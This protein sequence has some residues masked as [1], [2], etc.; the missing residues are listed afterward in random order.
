LKTKVIAYIFRNKDK[1]KEIL[2]FKHRDFP[3]AGL[4]VIGGT[5]D[6]G[7]DKIPALIREIYEEAGLI[8]SEYDNI[9]KI[10]ET[11]YQRRDN[12]EINHRHYYIIEKND[13]PNSWAHTVHSNG[14]DNGLVFEFFWM[15]IRE[16]KLS[17]TGNFAELLP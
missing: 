16:A 13:L 9:K 2:V 17:L 7:E 11:H 10:G 14:L 1:K 12:G 15:D 5:V 3:Q 6:P 8:F 4:Q